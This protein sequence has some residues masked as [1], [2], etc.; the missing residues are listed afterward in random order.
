MSSMTLHRGWRWTPAAILATL[1]ILVVV[2]V[3][4]NP[5]TR[6][7][8]LQS[9]KQPARYATAEVGPGP[10]KT[11]I[12]ARPYTVGIRMAPNRP[13]LRNAV[14]LRLTDQSGPVPGAR[15]TVTFSMP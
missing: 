13:A 8:V 5:P 4:S 14:S 6:G 12:S 3:S 15:V 1:A 2:V 7:S 9:L 10:V 11:V